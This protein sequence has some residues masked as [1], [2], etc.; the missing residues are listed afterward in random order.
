[1]RRGAGLLSFSFAQQRV[2]K[3]RR[4]KH[5]LRAAVFLFLSSPGRAALTEARNQGDPAVRTRR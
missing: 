1:L 2:W 4:F 3:W 5:R